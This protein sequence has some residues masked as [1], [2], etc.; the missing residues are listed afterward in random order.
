MSRMQSDINSG[1]STPVISTDQRVEA[2]V[3][4]FVQ[5]EVSSNVIRLR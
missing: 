1:V 3:G 2:D 5:G 4:S